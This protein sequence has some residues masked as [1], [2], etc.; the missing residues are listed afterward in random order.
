VQIVADNIVKQGAG[1]PIEAS[2]DAH[3]ILEARYGVKFKD[4]GRGRRNRVHNLV[5]DDMRMLN[6][7]A[8]PDDDITDVIATAR[9]RA[10]GVD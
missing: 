10:K 7:L 6:T 5:L 1:E 3:M 4:R 8:D 2:T 9:K